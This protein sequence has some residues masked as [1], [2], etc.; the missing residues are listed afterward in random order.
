[1]NELQKRIKKI[2]SIRA[3]MKDIEGWREREPKNDVLLMGT[4]LHH[5]DL[6]K[7]NIGLTFPD[8]DDKR[9][10]LFIFQLGQHH[11]SQDLER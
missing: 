5:G 7:I 2:S 6:G 1:M 3:R 9:V 4:S 11:H 8:T 10:I